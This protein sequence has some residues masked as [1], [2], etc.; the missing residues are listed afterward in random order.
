MMNI[1]EDFGSIKATTYE[2]EIE[3]RLNALNNVPS[4]TEVDKSIKGMWFELL[5]GNTLDFHTARIVLRFLPLLTTGSYL[6]A[7]ELH[8]ENDERKHN[9]LLCCFTAIQPWIEGP[10]KEEYARLIIT[11]EDQL[12]A[13]IKKFK[14]G[15]AAL[16]LLV[17]HHALKLMK[18]DLSQKQWHFKEI[19]T[20][21]Q[22]LLPA[23]DSNIA[24]EYLKGLDIDKDL[25]V[26]SRTGLFP[27]KALFEEPS[28]SLNDVLAHHVETLINLDLKEYRKFYM[29]ALSHG[30]PHVS[31]LQEVLDELAQ[32]KSSYQNQ[33]SANAGSTTQDLSASVL[34]ERASAEDHL[35]RAQLVKSMADLF[36]NT[37]VDESLTI[38][39]LGDWGAGKTSVL[40]Q[41]A[42]QLLSRR[43]LEYTTQGY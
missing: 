25:N 4:K 18:S 20:A 39:L 12:L 14:H 30:G 16:A 35:G 8:E 28:S 41:L 33:G 1:E 31:F 9:F 40:N 38:G 21:H 27:E 15:A 5:P 2:Q 17:C 29:Q 26:D 23:Y 19:L 13:D 6:A 34:S 7:Q 22:I 11:D 43:R 32:R 36:D 37:K 3:D 10:S 24:Q 42:D